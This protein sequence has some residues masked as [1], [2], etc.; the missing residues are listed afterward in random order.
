MTKKK[1]ELVQLCVNKI[2]EYKERESF[3]TDHDKP[4]KKI[5][6]ED[7]DLDLSSHKN[8]NGSKFIINI[9]LPIASACK[10]CYANSEKINVGLCRHSFCKDCLKQYIENLINIGQVVK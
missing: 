6:M 9:D 10:I 1:E 8:E 5:I 7:V 2:E 3:G 4:A